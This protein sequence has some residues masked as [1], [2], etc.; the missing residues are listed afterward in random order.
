MREDVRMKY[1]KD[2]NC[3]KLHNSIVTL[4]KFDGKHIGHQ[5]LFNTAIEL[6]N[7]SVDYKTVIFTFDVHVS[8]V[9]GHENIQTILSHEEKTFKEYAD[10]I[11]YVVEFPFNETTKNMSPEVFVKEV[12]VQKLDT[13]A[14]V[15]GEDFC[16]GKDRKGN[17]DV[18]KELGKK[19]GFDVYAL[20]KVEYKN[21]EVSSTLIKEELVKGNLEDV[22]EMLGTAFSITS[23]VLHGKHFGNTI[24]FPTINFIVPDEKIMP[25]N[26]VYATKTI[27]DG[28]E[29]L[30]ITNVGV[31][32]TFDD[33]DKRTVE[34]NIINFDDDIYDKTV[35]VKF[36]KFIRPE[37][38]FNS[39]DD[40]KKEIEK[41]TQTVIDLGI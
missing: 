21:K 6:K 13:K 18:L 28:K 5:L 26:G 29:Y 3:E 1:I 40:L 7:N 41:N 30:S 17:V 33:G 4:G 19:F 34:T 23:K 15:V 22:N 35:E 11:D 32:P 27:I 39:V 25:P 37:M 9:V 8:K 20:K 14:I 16:F 12:L 38:K 2:L 31:R 24:G 10:K 36:Y